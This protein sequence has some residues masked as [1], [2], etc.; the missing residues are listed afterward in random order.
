MAIW[1]KCGGDKLIDFITV[2]GVKGKENPHYINCKW[3]DLCWEDAAVGQNNIRCAVS[4]FLTKVFLCFLVKRWEKEKAKERKVN[5]NQHCGQQMFPA[6]S[7][8]QGQNQNTTF[9]LYIYS[10]Y[11]TEVGVFGTCLVSVY[12]KRAWQFFYEFISNWNFE[13]VSLSLTNTQE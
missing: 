9:F 7:V 4:I 12:W 1:F 6:L 11:V 10:S 3:I 13:N 5:Q 2:L 8:A